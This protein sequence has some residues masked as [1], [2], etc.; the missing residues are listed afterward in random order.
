MVIYAQIKKILLI[1]ESNSYL[2][3]TLVD[4]LLAYVPWLLSNRK[5][6]QLDKKKVPQIKSS[7]AVS[8]EVAES[9]WEV[10]AESWNSC[11]FVP[12]SPIFIPQQKN[13]G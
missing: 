8:W 12:T 13:Q 5:S 6:A 11:Y 3:N 7:T 2:W 9:S 1:S 4:F 10:A